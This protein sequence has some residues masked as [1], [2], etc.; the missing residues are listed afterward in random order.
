M[1]NKILTLVLAIGATVTALANDYVA[2]A[3]EGNVYDEANA[4][5]ITL[6]QNN[7]DVTLIPGMVFE[8]SQRTP[9]WYKIEYSPGLHG[10]I[11]EQIAASTFKPIVAGNYEVSNNPGQSINI[12][13]AGNDW[14]AEADGKSYKGQLF[15][16]ILIFRDNSNNIMFTLVDI[17][18]GP[19]V[20][21]YDNKITKF[22]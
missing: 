2:V 11:P 20:I 18:N 13:Q 8:T 9:G 22:F 7:E 16:D 10:F 5:Y 19:I 3:K 14:N 12:S 6:N 1:K 15:E 21:T 4:K 17:G